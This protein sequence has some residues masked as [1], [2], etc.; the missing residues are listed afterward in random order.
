MNLKPFKPIPKHKTDWLT[1]AVRFVCG[2][3]FG[4]FAGAMMVSRRV[5]REPLMFA[6][7]DDISIPHYYLL[8]MLC[9]S[10]FFGILAAIFGDKFWESF[11]R[12]Y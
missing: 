8:T 3:V 5:V 2:A 1:Y 10:A 6:I 11:M 9:I 12:K 4:A 7:T